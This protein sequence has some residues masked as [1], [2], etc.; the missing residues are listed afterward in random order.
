MKQTVVI[1]ILGTQLDTGRQANRWQKW[2]P[3]V[4]LF[5]HEDLQI[6]RLELLYP[7]SHHTLA[8]GIAT[9]IANVS[10]DTTVVLHGID[11]EDAWDF[12]EVF[13]RLHQFARDYP[14]DTDH[15]DYLIHITT[16]SHV[17]QICLFLLTET[18]H[19][20]GR[21]LQGAPPKRNAADL[22]G[23]YRI[24]DLD[25]SRYD[26]LATR[27]ADERREGSDFLKAGIA[28]RNKQFNQMMD[29]IERVAIASTAP[30]LLTGPTGAG[31]TQLARRIYELKRRREQISGEFV[32]INCATL[33]GDQA[34]S[35][36]FG[37]VKGAFTGAM[38]N[39]AGLLKNGD[40]GLVLLD[41]IGE[42]G[43]DE[44]AMLLRAIEEKSF[45]PVGADRECESDFQLLAGTNR[46]LRAKVLAG[47]FREDL[48][49]R[50]NLWTFQLP[51]LADR[52]EDIEPN[53]DFELD[54][55]GTA[56]GR[57][58]SMTREARVAFLRFANSPSALWSGNFRDLS[59]AV[60]RMATFAA[61]GRIGADQV[62]EEKEQLQKSWQLGSGKDAETDPVLRELLGDDV[63]TRFDL[64]DRIQLA[65]VVDIC[66]RCRSIS[67]AGRQLFAVSRETRSII[68][69]ADRLRKFL[70]RFG[71]S[72]NDIQ[73]KVLQ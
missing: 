9:D 63:V 6:D 54:R 22:P 64:F 40:K 33:R 53:L 39:R 27:F 11:F 8:Q 42:L 31:K 19:L 4:S 28:T 49:A 44:Q 10:P 59:A 62:S 46:D 3:T 35:A 47:E 60:T 66:R 23:S 24:I 32:E 38:A 13:G 16:G 43:L 70:A 69:D 57:K 30:I 5:Q 34:M 36:M 7:E 12:E 48:L 73:T 17:Q 67:E 41:E 51:G 25:L 68:N 26:K 58:I 52:R 15:N 29:R 45:L 1:G 65:V 37:H 72:W 50:I 18:R 61:S 20:P 55:I 56:T 21:L 71:L 14:F 2:R